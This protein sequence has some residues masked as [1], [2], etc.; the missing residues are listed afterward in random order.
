MAGSGDV[1]GVY[2]GLFCGRQVAVTVF[3]G[4]WAVTVLFLPVPPVE[5]ETSAGSLE[6]A[7]PMGVAATRGRQ[8][9]R[10]DLWRWRP[11]RAMSQ[12]SPCIFPHPHSGLYSQEDVVDAGI[13]TNCTIV[14][15]YYCTFYVRQN[16][17]CL[18]C[19]RYPPLFGL[20]FLFLIFFF[21]LF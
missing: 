19:L 5:E 7:R 11:S 15:L 4:C 2:W 13:C 8:P 3:L 12:T 6:A 16:I 18:S 21:F 20:F 14:H 10:G 9:M 1:T 17:F